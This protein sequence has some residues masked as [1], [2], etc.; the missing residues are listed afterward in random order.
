MAAMLPLQA[1]RKTEGYD[2]SIINVL[3]I[4]AQY[5]SSLYDAFAIQDYI[6]YAISNMDTE[7]FLLVG[8]D[9]HDYLNY[10]SN[11][12][13]YIPSLYTPTYTASGSE[14]LYGNVDPM[15]TDVDGNGV[16]DGKIGRF[17]VQTPLEAQ[18]LV[19]KTLAYRPNGNNSVFMADET[20]G[21]ESTRFAA[22]LP[23]AWQSLVQTVYLDD[24]RDPP[25]PLDNTDALEA[26]AD[27]VSAVNGGVTIG[28]Y[29]GHGAIGR[30][31]ISHEMMNV[32]VVQSQLTNVGMPAFIVQWGCQTSLFSHQTRT[33]LSEAFVM[34]EDSGAVGTFAA[35]GYT[36]AYH[37]EE[38]ALALTGRIVTPGKTVGDAIQ[39]ARVV[40]L[41]ARS[42]ADWADVMLGL[43]LLGDPT[44]VLVPAP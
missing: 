22:Q 31:G 41:G 24:Y 30:W 13:P 29:L 28:S 4:Y 34:L 1:Q 36:S 3:D 26:R 14:W 43:M 6:Q 21:D 9:T 25:D 11:A 2:V 33:S 10:L 23:N 20:F 27:F 37:D 42:P 39:E 17:P 15:Y 35:T 12:V 7:Y 8:D 19:E 18:L 44:L 38:L 16:P 40:T 32:S 5:G